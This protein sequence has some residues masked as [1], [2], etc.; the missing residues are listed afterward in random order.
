MDSGSRKTGAGVLAG[1]AAAALAIG[2]FAG[3]WFGH[4]GEATFV[5]AKNAHDVQGLLRTLDEG[6]YVESRA[7]SLF[8]SAVTSLYVN[9]SL[10]NQ[11]TDWRSFVQAN[12]GTGT[13]SSQQYFSG[14]LGQLETAV[15]LAE[16][17]PPAARR[18]WEVC[19]PLSF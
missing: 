13:T 8:C 1:L 5:G 6:T 7:K 15:D 19:K 11:A 17:S 9:G 12:T 3:G 10:P 14:K 16:R 4:A 2:H 18:Y